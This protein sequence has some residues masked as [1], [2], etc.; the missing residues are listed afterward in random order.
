MEDNFYKEIPRPAST[1]ENGT[2]SYLATATLT[3]K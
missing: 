2:Q 1:K 3:S